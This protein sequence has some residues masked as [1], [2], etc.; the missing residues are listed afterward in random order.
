MFRQTKVKETGIITNINGNKTTIE[1]LKQTTENCKSCS[2]CVEVNSSSQYIE[3]E[4]VPGLKEGQL[5]VTQ[6]T[7]HS[8]YKSIILVFVFPLISLL[9][10]SYIGQN[11]NIFHITSKDIRVIV[12]GF[13]FFIASLIIASVYDRLTKSKTTTSQKIIFDNLHNSYDT[14]FK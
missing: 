8:P 6:K 3:V 4:T 11:Y 12:S 9:I 1:L 2:G 5:V 14:V 13:I 7:I 10:G